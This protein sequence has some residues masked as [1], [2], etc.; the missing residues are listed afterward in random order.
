M[1]R[2]RS[3]I[4]YTICITSARKSYRY[5]V[6][7][8]SPQEPPYFFKL[9]KLGTYSHL[10][11][12]PHESQALTTRETIDEQINLTVIRQEHRR[13]W[14][15]LRKQVE[16]V[17]VLPDQDFYFP[18]DF[19]YHYLLYYRAPLS[20][21]EML[22][23]VTTLARVTEN[24]EGLATGNHSQTQTLVTEN[25]FVLVMGYDYASDMALIMQEEE[26]DQIIKRLQE[27]QLANF[28]IEKYA[29]PSKNTWYES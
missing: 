8:S 3:L 9:F 1:N 11:Y 10:E 12:V 15:L 14:G 27:L 18:F 7:F 29:L 2:K 23:K 6:D 28:E 13:F 26:T 4:N 24:M 21:K 17:V 19:G 25:S 16:D 5:R 20:F 22:A